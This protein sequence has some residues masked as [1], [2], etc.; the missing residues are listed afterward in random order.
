MT[1]TLGNTPIFPESIVAAGLQYLIGVSPRSL[2][3]IYGT[4]IASVHH[5]VDMFLNTVVKLD[6]HHLSVCLPYSYFALKRDDEG[7]LWFV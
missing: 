5:L 3:F 1:F 4:S 7:F 6:D 2:M